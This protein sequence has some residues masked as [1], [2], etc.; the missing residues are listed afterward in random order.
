MRLNRIGIKLVLVM[1]AMLAVE[2]GVRY[3]FTAESNAANF[4]DDFMKSARFH[5]ESLAQA[6]EYGLLTRDGRELERVADM[7]RLPG[8]SDLL[9][10]AFYD[11]NGE[12]LASRQWSKEPIQ[13]SKSIK[14]VAAFTVHLCN[15][16][17]HR[18]AECHEFSVPVQVSQAMVG[19][20]EDV[21]KSAAGGAAAETATVVAVRSCADVLARTKAD[22]RK[23]L[24]LSS[25]ILGVFTIILIVLAFQLV[26]PIRTLAAG[27]ERV[28]AGNLE[29]DVDI[30]RRR[31]EF[32]TLA[33]SFNRMTAQLRQQ[34]DQI[35]SHNRELE[36]KVAER[37][38]ELER[39]NV[40]L[41]EANRSL[42][43]LATTDELTGLCNR[44]RFLEILTTEV[45]R[46]NRYG[47]NLALVMVD[48]D[49][50]KIINDTY[51]HAFGDRVLVEAAQLLR[52]EARQTDLVARYGG[53]EFMVLMPNTS[54]EEA[55]SAAERIRTKVGHRHISD[56]DRQVH[57]SI[58]A[59]ISAARPQ[60]AATP[61]GLVRAADEALYTAKHS[62]RDCTKTAGQIAHDTVAKK[63]INSAAVETLRLQATT[64]SAQSR[65]ALV[66][67]IY[68]LIHAHEARD[69]YA[70]AHSR[71]V[72]HF[73]LRVASAMGLDPQQVETIR[74][75]GLIHDIGKIA[76]P[77]GIL[78]KPGALTTEERLVMQQHV[79]VGVRILEQMQFLDREI[80]IV[81]HHHER[82]DG[83]GY[84]DGISGE[85]IPLGSR[86]LAVADALDSIT[87]ERS[88]RQARTVAQ[89]LQVLVEESGRQFD[90]D[91]VDAAVQWIQAVRQALGRPGDLTAADLLIEAGAE[92]DAALLAADPPP[93]EDRP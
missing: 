5:A 4:H 59:G 27:T 67:G 46:S 92:D 31:D 18:L 33:D 32:R 68:G 61:D 74:R 3:Y 64:L 91:V 14:P 12:L 6:A 54:T 48:I 36:R 11:E 16:P 21:G 23:M 37:T 49:Q 85:A 75:A 34:R 76:V 50:F 66:Q 89:A 88:Y 19:M 87:A 28:A 10:V 13:V 80:P 55:V 56:G 79:V 8:D 30:G 1:A 43:A 7:L 77:D 93:R 51:G 2:A 44:R 29:T 39:A 42:E 58:S 71:N 22:Q 60:G 83:H 65:T 73:A 72:A 20:E 53:D 47:S 84:P 63:A 15:N 40:Q 78:W 82:Y 17:D 9:Y 38:A 45:E 41:E 35:L 81:R 70:K 90:P 69:P 24:V 62:G 26:R 52:H 57:L 25:G 86:I